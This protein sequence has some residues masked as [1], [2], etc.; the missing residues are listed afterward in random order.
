MSPGRAKDRTTRLSSGCEYCYMVLKQRSETACGRQAVFSAMVGN[1]IPRFVARL[2]VEL[3]DSSTSVEYF[4]QS[5]RRNGLK[6]RRGSLKISPECPLYKRNK[7][8]GTASS[9]KICGDHP[10]CHWRSDLIP[11]QQ[12][13]GLL[14]SYVFGC[15]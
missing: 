9:G 13:K 5:R 3:S 1:S 15:L 6:Y 12:V 14:F 10:K 4:L 11:E 7:C 8:C 2:G